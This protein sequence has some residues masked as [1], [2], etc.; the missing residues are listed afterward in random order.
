MSDRTIVGFISVAG[1]VLV[2]VTPVIPLLLHNYDLD[3]TYLTKA[4]VGI[5][6][7]ICGYGILWGFLKKENKMPKSKEGRLQL[8]MI[9]LIIG[10]VAIG[11]AWFTNLPNWLAVNSGLSETFE[12]NGEIIY[13]GLGTRIFVS[14]I[15]AIGVICL[16]FSIRRE[17]MVIAKAQPTAG[18]Y[19]HMMNEGGGR[20]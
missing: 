10:V 7:L 4:I 8:H 2:A 16:K 3:N 15:T 14:A 20:W 17:K 6:T 13:G 9:L 12:S 5:V 18:E 1:F 19:E 11:L